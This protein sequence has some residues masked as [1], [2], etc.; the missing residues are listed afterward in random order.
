MWQADNTRK[1]QNEFVSAMKE[2]GYRIMPIY[3]EIFSI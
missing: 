3:E 2:C 1:L